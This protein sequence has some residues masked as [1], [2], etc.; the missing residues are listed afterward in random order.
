MLQ[1]RIDIH[2]HVIPPA[3]LEA[4]A[5]KGISQVAGAPLPRWTPEASMAVMDMN[6]IQTAMTSISAPG[7][8]FGSVPDACDLARRC[9]EFSADVKS[10]YPG[11]FG[12]LAVLPM[13]FTEQACKEAVYA[14]DTLLA[15]GIGLLGSTEGKFLGDPAFEEL[16]AELD[17]RQAAVFVHPNLHATS[18]AIGLN[19]PGFLIE[20]LCDTTR[21]ALNLIVSGT[22]EKY[23]NIRWILAHAGGFL[24]YVAWRVSLGNLMPEV[25][26]HAPQ[27][28]LAYIKRFYFDTALSPS[29]Y[30]MAALKELVEPSHILFGSDFP[31]APAAIS[32]LQVQ[33][34]D[35]SP[36][37]DD[38]TKYG[39]NRGHALS[40]FPAHKRVDEVVALQP[41]YGQQSFSVRIMRVLVKPL[42][43]VADRLRNK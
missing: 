24:P 38:N 35:R 31:F 11:R 9:N 21:A 18:Q 36:I 43:A 14:L 10:R 40:L 32:A 23:P 27:G 29:P 3:F 8:Y 25:S 15:D 30:T 39:I 6:G 12:S 20:F 16:M 42:V 5:D 28:M 7:V 37:W 26:Q 41:V 2:H 19:V 33:T 1:G 34:L 17:R 22:T 4:M 13:P